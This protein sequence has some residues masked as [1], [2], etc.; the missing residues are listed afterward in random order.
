[1]EID[2]VFICVEPGAPEAEEFNKFGLSE[3]SR[4]K[5]PGQGTKNRRFFFHNCCI[6]FLY[7]KSQLEL[8]SELTK[9]TKLYQRLTDKSGEV[10]PF[11][12]CF[13]PG[14]V[15]EK[16]A[17]FPHWAY[18]PNYLPEQLHIDIGK[19]PISEPMWFYLSFGLRPDQLPIENQQPLMH[20]PNLSELTALRLTIPN[21][22]T[23][24]SAAAYAAKVKGVEIEQGDRHLLEFGFDQEVANQTHDFRPLLPIVFRW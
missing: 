11:G 14:P 18:K 9:P 7:I 17:P 8:Q 5:H 15:A 4:N 13:R 6:E 21:T 24:S 20:S 1:M 16:Q 3:G 10:S 12:V 19:S 2:H 22:K 23:I